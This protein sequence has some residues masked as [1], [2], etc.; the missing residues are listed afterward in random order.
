[1]RLT[2]PVYIKGDTLFILDQTLLP[3]EEKYIAITDVDQ[4][5][6]AIKSLRVRGA[7][8]IGI[9]AAYGVLLHILRNGFSVPKLKEVIHKLAATRPT[10]VNLFKALE[11]IEK[12]LESGAGYEQVKEIIETIVREE[13]EA[14]LR[15]AEY[16]V[17]EVKGKRAL[18]ICNTG[19]LATGGI[20]TALGIIYKL[21][22][23]GELEMVYVCETRPLLQGARLTA[24]ELSKAGIP[25]RLITDNTAGYVM[26]LGMVDFV[27]VGA[28]RIS[29]T[30]DTANKIGSLTLAILAKYYGIPFHVVAPF[31]T[32]DLSIESGE[33]IPIEQRSDEEVTCVFGKRIAPEGAK[34]LNFA[35]DVIPSKLITSIITDKGVAKPPYRDSLKKL[36]L[37]SDTE[38]R[39]D[40]G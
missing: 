27:V 17:Q 13:K 1:M 28:D 2:D 11:R 8:L 40:S 38:I 25:Y 23:K 34:A 32:V 24:W 29:A 20:G 39:E 36:A 18:T 10:A 4:L 12:A 5:C 14:T 31:T 19:V 7:P 33:D 22:E 37:F 3:L 6:E 9:A 35:F 30:G 26:S 21:F 16:G 15:M